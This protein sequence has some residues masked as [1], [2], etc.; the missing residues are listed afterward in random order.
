MGAQNDAHGVD[1]LMFF[2][3]DLMKHTYFYSKRKFFGQKLKIPKLFH[4]SGAKTFSAK[5]FSLQCFAHAY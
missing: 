4:E 1:K 3:G 5:S 2:K